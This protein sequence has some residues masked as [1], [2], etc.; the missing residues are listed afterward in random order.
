MGNHLMWSITRRALNSCAVP[1]IE[2]LYDYIESLYDRSD[3]S[4]C[5]RGTGGSP[6]KGRPVWGYVNEASMDAQKQFMTHVLMHV[7]G[8]KRMK[9][10]GDNHGTKKF[11][12]KQAVSL[13]DE[14]FASLI[15]ED[16][17]VLWKRCAML[18]L[19]RKKLLDAKVTCESKLRDKLFD[20]WSDNEKRLSILQGMDEEDQRDRDDRGIPSGINCTIYSTYGSDS[21]ELKIFH[22]AHSI[23]RMNAIRRH[24]HAWRESIAGQQRLVQIRDWYGSEIQSGPRR[25]KRKR[26]DCSLLNATVEEETDFNPEDIALFAQV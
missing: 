24:L 8:E 13:S 7:V 17:W 26:D 10:M 21:A 9:S 19:E 15:V 20:Q 16:R 11:S 23:T 1:E 22:K 5:P 6:L 14:V 4:E 18:R 3:D 2:A 12:Y 25:R